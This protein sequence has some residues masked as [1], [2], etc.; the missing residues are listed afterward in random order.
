MS[1]NK[2][3]SSDQKLQTLFEG[4]RSWTKGHPVARH[5]SVILEREGEGAWFTT[6]IET[7]FN[8]PHLM[9]EL[10]DGRG[11]PAD[12]V[13]IAGNVLTELVGAQRDQ[14]KKIGAQMAP[15]EFQAH[16]QSSWRTDYDEPTG[17]A[18]VAIG[19]PVC[20]E[21]GKCIVEQGMNAGF[22]D[23]RDA[24]VQVFGGAEGRRRGEV[25]NA[26]AESIEAKWKE[27]VTMELARQ[28]VDYKQAKAA[29]ANSGVQAI[30]EGKWSPAKGYKEQAEER[31][32]KRQGE[33]EAGA[34]GQQGQTGGKPEPEG[35]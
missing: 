17:G 11:D 2:L 19:W 3:W 29:M 20:Y 33:L 16:A 18:A 27:E 14:L 21:E 30:V 5:K 34:P 4:F 26:I 1:N 12:W 31:G 23:G 25:F 10:K 35:V 22:P 6:P 7:W 28:G 13:N 24:G 15:N 8:D 32:Q 9:K